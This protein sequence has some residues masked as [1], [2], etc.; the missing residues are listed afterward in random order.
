MATRCPYSVLFFYVR[1]TVFVRVVVQPG[2]VNEVFV[3]S[4]AG[5]LHFLILLYVHFHY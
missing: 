1:P 4:L 2:L 5:S 3:L